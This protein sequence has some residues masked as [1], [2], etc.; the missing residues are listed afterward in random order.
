MSCS[1]RARALKARPD[2]WAPHCIL[3][4][5][6]SVQAFSRAELLRP[7]DRIDIDAERILAQA[8]RIARGFDDDGKDR[9][10]ALRRG[11]LAAVVA[12]FGP[13]D[14]KAF[15]RGANDAGDLDCNLHVAELG[16]GV[17]G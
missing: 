9:G 8:I 13:C 15:R 2:V 3:N 16:K 6:T 4:Q 7:V 17:V 12:A 10:P 5:P 14:P 11:E 1:R